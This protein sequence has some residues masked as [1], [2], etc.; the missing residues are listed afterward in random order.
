MTTSYYRPS[1]RFSPTLLPRLVIMS[2]L[3]V[4]FAWLYAY[5][6]LHFNAFFR[7]FTPLLF[8]TVLIGAG[9]SLGNKAQVRNPTLMFCAALL[10][11]LLAWYCQWAFWAGMAKPLGGF[12][13]SAF[14]DAVDYFLKP[15]ALLSAV[16]AP[17]RW[18]GENIVGAMAEF[19]LF[20]ILPTFMA[21]KAAREPFCETG[22]TW[23]KEEKL[24]GPFGPIADEDLPQ[25]TKALEADPD[26]FMELLPAYSP[27][28]SHYTSLGIF[29]TPEGKDAWLTIRKEKVNFVDGKPNNTWKEI[30]KYLRISP[31]IAQQTRTASEEHV[32]QAQEAP[33]PVELEAALAAM[34]DGH[35]GAA[36]LGAKP[37]VG[38][39]DVALRTDANRLCAISSSQLE[40]WADAATY[41]EAVFATERSAH[42]ALQ[43]ATSKVMAG[44][45]APGEQW[46]ATAKA[47]NEETQDVSATLLHT[48]FISALKRAGF[49]AAAR[50]YM[51]WVKQVYEAAHSTDPTFLTLRGVP[52]FES[53][54]DQ[55]APVVDAV[56]DAEQA[57]AWYASMLA[58]IDQD[59]QDTLNAW[60][61]QRAAMSSPA[62]S[63]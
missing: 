20:V 24:A 33:T 54:L 14:L 26:N 63:L 53:F 46:L 32:D 57:H 17:P 22:K 8:A 51:E 40:K 16:T 11:T 37:F 25:F 52:F 10:L 31:A 30:V 58:H 3:T 48:N 12:I 6:T 7:F 36:L 62:A 13:N 28:T 2:L 43:V 47:V 18:N 4:L 34:Q 9:V 49:L 41:F 56:M 1:G 19:I 59:G 50:P 23:V 60:L 15:A 55:S 27:E 45:L 44:E 42:N 29:S 61:G 35:F 21:R 5:S 38:A 39:A